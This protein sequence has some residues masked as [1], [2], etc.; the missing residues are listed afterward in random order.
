MDEF[1]AVSTLTNDFYKIVRQYDKY[2]L[3]ILDDW[4]YGKLDAS[5]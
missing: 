5:S 1:K 2:D 3:L 4:G